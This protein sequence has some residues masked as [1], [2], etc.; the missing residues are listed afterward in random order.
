MNKTVTKRNQRSHSKRNNGV[1]HRGRTEKF[2]GGI[3]QISV[4]FSEENYEWI[5]RCAEIQTKLRGVRVYMADVIGWGMDEYIKTMKAQLEEEA[6][7]L[8]I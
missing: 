2:P 8:K 6:K 5:K 4:G 3:K 1:T 7:K